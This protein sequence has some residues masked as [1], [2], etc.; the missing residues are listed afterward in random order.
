MTRQIQID[1]LRA[2]AILSVLLYHSGV[3]FFSG[4]FIG[5]DVFFVI[6]GY[7]ITNVLSTAPLNSYSN[8][9]NFFES[10]IRRIVPALY[11]MLLV[12]TLA[13][14]FL[15]IPTDLHK[16]SNSLASAASFTSNIHFWAARDG[17]FDVDSF[18]S[19]LIHTWS[20]GIEMQFYLAIFLIF[21]VS[22]RSRFDKT[23]FI[24][25]FF[26]LS[27]A[28][29]TYFSNSKPGASFFLTPFR[30]WELLFG[31]LLSLIHSKYDSHYQ[32]IDLCY[33]NIISMTGLLGILVS[34][35][36]FDE[37]YRWPS[38]FALL[39][40][41]STSLIILFAVPRTYLYRLL[42]S[43]IFVI[44][45]AASYSIYLYH[46]PIFAFYKQYS[47]STPNNYLLL[48]CILMTLGFSYLSYRLIELPFKS[49]DFIS[50]KKIL[51]SALIIGATLLLFQV[52]SSI[53]GGFKFRYS[54][55]DS[56]LQSLERSNLNLNCYYQDTP[57]NAPIKVCDLGAPESTPSFMVIGDS[58]ALSLYPAINQAAI[59]KKSYGIFASKL[60]CPPL[61]DVS[62]LNST[63]NQCKKFNDLIFEHAKNLGIKDIFLI[64]KWNLYINGGYDELHLSRIVYENK[65]VNLKILDSEGALKIALKNTILRYQNAGIKVHLI[66]QIPQQITSPQKIFY[67][68][69]DDKDLSV[70][71]TKIKEF[72][73]HF[74]KHQMLNK[75]FDNLINEI[76][77]ELK[78]LNVISLDYVFCSLE[79][80]PI[81]NEDASYY[82]DDNHLSHNGAFLTLPAI[83]KILD[84]L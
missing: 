18:L 65:E 52:L 56:I 76:E 47:L 63:S 17:Y 4:G 64:S 50:L 25:L 54:L 14:F 84:T 16:F 79:I 80:C 3:R 58:H 21:L 81:G 40:V 71:Q 2:V 15:L 1:G 35:S 62:L 39:P 13:S 26:F 8:T 67:K 78:N 46:Q 19:P 37:N 51:I 53:T 83:E 69:Y 22:S 42:S 36:I 77:V 20:L 38:Y 24:S 61:L 60:G 31:A 72:S 82:Y 23:I 11:V 32:K 74:K 9:F 5:V 75:Q 55:P 73:V 34:A 10:R 43:P 41:I 68:Y 29:S 45:G 30:I 44:L 28:L 59:S 6:S 12:S 7:L 33:K 48:A 27:L 66:K 49:R 57:I 70:L